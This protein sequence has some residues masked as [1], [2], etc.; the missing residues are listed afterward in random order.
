MRVDG[1]GTDRS[2]HTDQFPFAEHARFYI[3]NN[4]KGR[5]ALEDER[6]AHGRAEQ[7]PE[8]PDNPDFLS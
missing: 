6:R 5:A 3:A 4:R 2:T 8:S 1:D 7:C